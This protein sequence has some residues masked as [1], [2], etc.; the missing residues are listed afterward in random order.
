M[1]SGSKWR[2]LSIAAVVATVLEFTPLNNVFYKYVYLPVFQEPAQGNMLDV[3]QVVGWCFYL[4]AVWLIL[5]AVSFIFG[6]P[7]GV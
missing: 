6:T 4:L 1:S 7:S 2:D 3:I 5:Q